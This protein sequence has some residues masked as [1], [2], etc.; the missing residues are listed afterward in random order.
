MVAT[1]RL[2][3][4]LATPKANLHN[5][6]H[7]WQSCLMKKRPWQPTAM[8]K[9]WSP[10]MMAEDQPPLR[11]CCKLKLNNSLR[12]SRILKNKAVILKC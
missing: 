8:K 4:S 9:N 10:M 3:G 1:N 5:A 12:S 11:R 2:S 7:M 6:K